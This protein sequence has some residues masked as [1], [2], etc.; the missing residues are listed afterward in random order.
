M[1]TCAVWLA[2]LAGAV[3]LPIR[4]LVPA[5]CVCGSVEPGPVSTVLF[6]ISGLI[7]GLAV[8]FLATKH[9]SR[10]PLPRSLIAGK[11]SCYPPGA[12]RES[13][14]VAQASALLL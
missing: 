8:G 5:K 2:Y 11:R 10:G 9:P 6:P 3:P 12:S 4:T 1:N 14:A 7:A 13:I